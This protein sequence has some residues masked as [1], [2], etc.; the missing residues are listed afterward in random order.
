MKWFSNNLFRM[1]STGTWMGMLLI[2]NSIA[3][4]QLPEVKFTAADGAKAD[5]FGVSTAIDGDYTVIG[6]HFDDDDSTNAGS[7]YVFKRSGTIWQQVAKLKAGDARPNANF[8]RCVAL[9]GE[10]VIVGAP[11]DRGASLRAGAAY[12]F[13]RT[14]DEGSTWIQE[15]KL[16]ASDAAIEDFFGI[17][18]DIDGDY[19][20]VGAHQ[21]DNEA[22]NNAGSAYIFKHNSEG[23]GW[24]QQAKLVASGVRG[25]EGTGKDHFGISVAI[26]S[27][28]V[29][30]GQ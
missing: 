25:E 30:I 8:G 9:S 6:A 24:T 11:G 10:Y 23:S 12:I 7:A 26:D 4:A 29:I 19:A 17:S 13:R 1:S 18:V 5:W 16:T 20:I 3:N 14:S 27:E 22:G 2:V 15:A 21:D 28:Y